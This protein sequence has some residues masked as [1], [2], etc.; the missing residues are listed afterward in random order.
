MMANAYQAD[1]TLLTSNDDGVATTPRTGMAVHTFEDDGHWT[2][3]K[4]GRYQQ[5]PAAGGSYHIVIDE[6]GRTCRENDDIYLPWSAM[7]TGNRQFWHVSLSG[8]AAW[9]REQWLARGVQ[10]DALADVLAHYSLTYGFPLVKRS[11]ANI[12]DG[13]WGV[14]GHADISAAWRESDHTDPGPGF[15]WDVVMDRAIQRLYQLKNPQSTTGDTTMTTLSGVSAA[16]LNEAKITARDNQV[17][18]RGPNLKGWPQ[19]GGRTLVDAVAAIG[20][21]LG[22]PDF[23]DTLKK[24]TPPTD[25]PA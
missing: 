16:A 5:D 11:A 20:T 3:E 15:P 17:Q 7:Y 18:L 4:M 23:H 14:C 22:L 9:T 12:R 6:H 21:H 2:A 8:K 25:S 24:V 10:L 1:V 19:L 13:K